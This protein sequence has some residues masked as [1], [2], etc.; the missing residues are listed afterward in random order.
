MT[1][2][3]WTDALCLSV[4][5]VLVIAGLILIYTGARLGGTNGTIVHKG[6]LHDGHVGPGEAYYNP[7]T[8]GEEF[9]TVI[10]HNEVDPEPLPP[11]GIAENEWID[12]SGEL[13]DWNRHIGPMGPRRIPPP[14]VHD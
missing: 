1:D 7:L 11:E 5:A 10:P 2:A 8:M 14:N 9:H 3:Q 13:F 6:K 4:L 12:P